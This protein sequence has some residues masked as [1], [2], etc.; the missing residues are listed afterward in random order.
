MT[1]TP[2]CAWTATTE[3]SAF[4]HLNLTVSHPMGDTGADMYVQYTIAGENRSGDEF[5][6]KVV[7][8]LTYGFGL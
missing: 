5:D 7:F 6:N 1:T 3:D 8:G 2:K 4:R